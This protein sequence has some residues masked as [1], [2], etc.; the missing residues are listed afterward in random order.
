MIRKRTDTEPHPIGDHAL[1]TTPE[2]DRLTL[3][4]GAGRVPADVFGRSVEAFLSLIREVSSSVT[5]R[6]D[7]IRWFVAVAQGSALVH[8]FPEPHRAEPTAAR[9]VIRAVQKGVGTLFKHSERPEH[10][11]DKALNAA[12]ALAEISSGG[13]DGD[14][15]PVR[16]V[17]SEHSTAF[18][19]STL[20][21]VDSILGPHSEAL[22][23]IEGRI[24]TISERRK[25]SFYIY[26]AL[27]DRPVRCFFGKE[28]FDDV[29]E[30]FRT[31]Q[32]ALVYGLVKYRSD[33][34][35]VSVRVEELRALR[36]Q[37]RLPGFAAVRGILRDDEGGAE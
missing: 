21:N 25:P 28:L 32:R 12:R 4:L 30:L 33:G 13:D 11:T 16:L 14:P 23:S 31:R 10:F 35:P 36:A 34:E 20:T 2:I 6:E 24:E 26:D 29:V 3:E 15:V 1:S 5:G 18:A 9:T 8:A 37:D 7:A 22:G 27:T 17:T 19:K